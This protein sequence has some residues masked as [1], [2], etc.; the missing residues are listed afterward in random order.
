MK[1]DP[2][3]TEQVRKSVAEQL[4]NIVPAA[5][6]ARLGGLAAALV[7]RA[8]QQ[9]S[10][11]INRA[12]NAAKY[13][14]GSDQVSAMDL[15]LQAGIQA[16]Q[17]IQIA[18]A[19]AQLQAPTVPAGSAGIFGRVV[20][21]TAAGV[22]RAT[23]VAV[24]QAGSQGGKATSSAD[25]SYQLVLSVAGSRARTRKAESSATSP[26]ISV[27]LEVLVKAKT[28]L[29][30]SEVLTLNPGDIVLRELSITAPAADK[31]AG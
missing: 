17:A 14:P 12:R 5:D 21:A 1:I 29:T 15:R 20:D 24:D 2:T 22:A 28:V 6:S 10:L 25:G 16:A 11:T 26:S 9:S 3:Y 19:R 23:V 27:H 30:S 13:G 8:A 31:N 4:P 18:Q 7:V